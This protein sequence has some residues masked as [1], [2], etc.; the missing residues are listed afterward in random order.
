MI[1]NELPARQ[2]PYKL[3]A[4]EGLRYAFGS[5]L[6]TIIARPDDL[7]QAAS[8]IILTGAKGAAFPDAPTPLHA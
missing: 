1:T 3:D 4:G 6:A 7:G 5:H 2:S 8:G